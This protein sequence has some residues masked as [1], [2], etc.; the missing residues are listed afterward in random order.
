[1]QETIQIE[2]SFVMC[3]EG[4]S[5][6]EFFQKLIAYYKLPRFSF[7]F[8]FEDDPRNE[9][10]DNI[11]THGRDGFFGMLSIIE[12]YLRLQPELR[13]QIKGILL[14]VDANSNEEASFRHVASQ[15][16]RLACFGVPERV[17]EL[18]TPIARPQH[19]PIQILV[20]PGN[21]RTGGLETLCI[22]ALRNTHNKEANCIDSLMSCAEIQ[23][24]E[25]GP[26]KFDKSY[27]QCLIAI[28]YRPNPTRGIRYAFRNYKDDPPAIDIS[29]TCFTAVAN[30]IRSFCHSV[31][32]SC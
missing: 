10:G 12:K 9:T 30:K 20:M 5:D 25:W 8:P 29:S 14:V 19:P 11:A 21:G 6:N 4:Q 13:E 7:P 15:A 26:E 18:S 27:L 31:G 28:T 22:E 1:M 16:R 32:V 23:K 17:D 2:H 24:D 3:C